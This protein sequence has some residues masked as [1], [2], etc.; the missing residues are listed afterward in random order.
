MGLFSTSEREKLRLFRQ[1]FIRLTSDGS[2]PPERQQVLFQWCKKSKLDWETARAHVRDRS[3]QLIRHHVQTI[4]RDQR[5]T[6]DE[7]VSLRRL[8][9]RLGLADQAALLDDFYTLIQH[10][11][12]ERIAERAAYL[13]SAPAVAA[14]KKDITAYDLP[15]AITAKLLTLLERQH[16]L[17]SLIAGVL[18]VIPSSVT[19][20][21]QEACHF[22]AHVSFLGKHGRDLTAGEG[23]LIVTSHRVLL[24]SPTG[25]ASAVWNAMQKIQFQANEWLELQFPDQTLAILHADAQFVSTLLVSAFRKYRPDLPV[26][27]QPNK[28]LA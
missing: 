10:T 17:A 23:L 7:V 4:V 12:T 9:R 13:G 15:P 24:L 22:E 8:Q 1:H 2:Y 25:G 3:L 27:I 5:V 26:P 28:R 11:I 19:L 20:H 21:A 18:P 16:Q 6:P 14:L